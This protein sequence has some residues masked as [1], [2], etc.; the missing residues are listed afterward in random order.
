MW[1][2][3]ETSI[4]IASLPLRPVED[5][6]RYRSVLV[7]APHPDDETLGCGGAIALLQQNNIPVRVLVISD[8]TQSH[9]NSKRFSADRLRQLREKET[10]A[11]LKILGL[12]D[13]D[14]TFLR[15]PDTAVPHFGDARFETVVEE[16]DRAFKQHN[17]D[18]VF[19]PWQQDQH[20]DHS[21]TWEIAHDCLQ[22]YSPSPRQLVYS[23]WGSCAAGLPS[24]PAGETGWRLDIRSVQTLKRQAAMAH[25]SQTT[26]LIDDDPS[27][28]RLTPEMLDNLIQPWETYLDVK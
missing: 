28:F 15:W 6:L 11:A 25:Q 3:K 2:S 18:L 19:L 21:A 9:P 12:R 5:L 16:C 4:P 26:N 22:A 1:A 13:G 23:I 17:P 7:V 20:C 10:R 27:G 24:L 14:A 8:G